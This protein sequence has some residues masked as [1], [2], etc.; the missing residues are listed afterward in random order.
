VYDPENRITNPG[1][2]QADLSGKR[3]G[4]EVEVFIVPKQ[5]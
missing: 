2:F 1:G 4:V 3:E 5:Y